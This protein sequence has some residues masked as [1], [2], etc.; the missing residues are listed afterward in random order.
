MKV[1][2]KGKKAGIII[3]IVVVIATIILFCF[4]NKSYAYYSAA[5]ENG[6]EW[7]F[8]IN[9]GKATEIYYYRGKIGDTLEIPEK[10]KYG[11]FEYPVISTRSNIRYNILDTDKNYSIKKVIL[12][13]SLITIGKNSFLGFNN[14]KEVEFGNGVKTISDYAFSGTSIGGTITLPDSVTSI[15]SYPFGS[16]NRYIT[17]VHIGSGITTESNL[18]NL[19]NSLS[20]VQEVTISESNTSFCSIDG[21]VYDKEVKKIIYCPTEKEV[22]NFVVPSTIITINDRVFYNRKLTGSLTLPDGLVSI[23][24]S[25]F[26]NT[27][28]SGTLVIPDSVTN[29]GGEAFSGC[30]NLT[31]L[32]MGSGITTIG[33]QAFFRCSSM[34]G[35]LDLGNN[36]SHIM[37]NTFNG[38]NFNKVV[39]GGRITEI[40]YNAL[41]GVSDL[42]INKEEGSVALNNISENKDIYIHWLNDTHRIVVNSIPG[43]KIINTM[44]NEEITTGNFDCETEFKYKIVVEDGYNYSNLKIVDVL[45]ENIDSYKQ[46]DYQKDHE[47][48]FDR[49]IRDRAIYVQNVSSD[50]DLALR[51][52]ATEVNRKAISTSRVPN[53][54]FNKAN[55]G[56]A[57]TKYPVKVNTNDIVTL[58]V[59]VYNEGMKDAKANKI[60]VYLPE[61]VELVS[62]NKINTEYDW[63]REGN[64]YTST[65]LAD[66]TIKK[67]IGNGDVKYLDVEILVKVT[68]SK[69]EDGASIL[70]NVF[71]EIEEEDNRD[72]DSTCGN[73]D[74][75]HTSSYRK[76]EIYNSNSNSI[77]E[78]QEDDDDFDTLVLLPKVKVDYNIKIN[79]VDGE[80]KVLLEGARF[81]LL[82]KEGNI[83]RTAETDE[84]GVLD[85][86]GITTY[87]E[88][89]DVYFIQ[90][91]E[92]PQGYIVTERKKVKVEVIKTIIDEEKGTYDV[93]VRCDTIDH[94][95]DTSTYKFAPIKTIEQLQKVGSGEIIEIDGINYEYNT[96]TNYKLMNDIDLDGIDW[97]PIIPHMDCVFDGNGH[98]ISNLTIL[99]QNRE[100]DKGVALTQGTGLFNSFSGIVEN[101]ELENVN[102]NYNSSNVTSDTQIVGTGAFAG[103]MSG[104]YII[105]CKASGL[106]ST[107]VKNIGGFIGHTYDGMVR[108]DN[109]INNIEIEARN[110]ANNVGGIIGCALGSISINNSTNNAVIKNTVYNKGGLVGYVKPSKY[111]DSSI[112]GAFDDGILNLY[113]ENTSTSGEYNV[114]L[115]T[116][117]G[118]TLELLPGARYSIYDENKNVIEGLDNIQLETGTLKLF[119][120]EIKALGVDIYYI[121]ENETIPNYPGLNGIIKAEVERYWDKENSKYKVRVTTSVL[122]KEEFDNDTSIPDSGDIKT[123]KVF[124]EGEIFTDTNIAKANWNSAKTEFI[125]C[126]NNGALQGGTTNSAGIVGASHGYTYIENCENTA[127]VN[128]NGNSAGIIGE[129]YAWENSDY[130]QIINCRNSGQIVSTNN[131][132]DS[133]AGIA[134]HV[135]ADIKVTKCTNAGEIASSRGSASGILGNAVGKIY[136]DSCRNEGTIN[137]H[138]DAS[139]CNCNAGGMLA[140]SLIQ[141]V[142]VSKDYTISLQRE[143]VAITI[144]NCENKGN[145]YSLGCEVS[146]IVAIA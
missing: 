133:A 97:N 74:A 41:R 123:E 137:T 102:I 64:K 2:M 48:I 140:K 28:I 73:V 94:M 78:G 16:S 15:G 124:E 105:N 61:N 145:I 121:K 8:S 45:L 65:Y 47:Y 125:N 13:D 90:E 18:N 80:T 14:L 53:L 7:V 29:I 32:N 24:N 82:D 69:F 79:M 127:I 22:N 111:K 6:V 87:D 20:G 4:C 31:G 37:S 70:K 83:I 85:F 107:S 81:N 76:E 50:T 9:G 12:P 91:V 92:T 132:L 44:T 75:S 138:D 19:V 115:Q 62:N 42:W 71:A 25:A 63:T 136:I 38:T 117:K 110:S 128:V 66:K 57:H 51:I 43:V 26:Y 142:E 93:K 89:T 99:Y 33:N 108:V 135:M 49:L 141:N 143:Q 109:C 58:K 112:N 139:N 10:V 35:S 130:V 122:T 52:F 100:D 21:I 120:Q 3:I 5:D 67:Y 39:V 30:S 131:S 46:F 129:L 134:A 104:G 54:K 103:I 68:A 11:K 36:L 77:I 116:I 84:N 95:I 96:D 113:V 144:T 27:Q 86:K 106:I 60:S 119:N 59:R 56:Y 114:I 55:I 40:G 23:G 72:V 17:N 1:Y 118:E 34:T 88:G 146:Y 98:K 126:V 101:L